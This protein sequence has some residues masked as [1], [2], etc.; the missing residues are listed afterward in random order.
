MSNNGTNVTDRLSLIASWGAPA[1]IAEFTSNRWG[2][3]KPTIEDT[4]RL[5]SIGLHG[6]YQ[7]SC[8]HGRTTIVCAQ[9][10]KAVYK[11]VGNKSFAL[12]TEEDL[13]AEVAAKKLAEETQAV[14]VT[15]LRLTVV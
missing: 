10:F 6:A 11:P 4:P 5:V 2:S 1:V 12:K 15:A 3:H 7:V 14:S 9:A 8:P 13:R